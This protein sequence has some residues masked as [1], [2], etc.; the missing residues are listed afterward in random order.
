MITEKFLNRTVDTFYVTEE[1]CE[2]RL[3]FRPGYEGGNIKYNIA[4]L[5]SLTRDYETIRDI[6]VPNVNESPGTYIIVF[7]NPAVGLNQYRLQLSERDSLLQELYATKELSCVED[8][9]E[10]N[11]DTFYVTEEDCRHYLNFRSSYEGGNLAYRI[12]RHDSVTGEYVNI[13]NIFAPDA[14]E[15]PISYSVEVAEPVEGL[16]EY[17]LELFQGDRL[18]EEVLTVK[19]FL[20]DTI[21]DIELNLSLSPTIT[22]D[23]IGVHIQSNEQ[24]NGQLVISKLNGGIILQQNIYLNEGNNN[25]FFDLSS[26]GVDSR[27]YYGVT[28]IVENQ[29]LNKIFFFDR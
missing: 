27:G 23:I 14:N 24:A 17:R 1:N 15:N 3:H 9:I 13:R 20:C 12:S 4:L 8:S 18:L 11:I 5:N 6:S 25:F 22:S 16:N 7:A 29:T 21:N 2:H 10:S 26:M 28:V 19:H